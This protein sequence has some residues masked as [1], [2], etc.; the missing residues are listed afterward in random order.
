[1]K[2]LHLTEE[3]PSLFE[4]QLILLPPNLVAAKNRYDLLREKSINTHVC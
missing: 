1:M 2:G 3:F 4:P